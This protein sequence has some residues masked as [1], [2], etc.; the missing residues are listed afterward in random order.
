MAEGATII[1]RLALAAV[2]QALPEQSALTDALKA[3]QKGLM[4]TVVAGVLI[5]A[6]LLLGVFG[7]YLLLRS[8][9]VSLITSIVLIGAVLF[10]LSAI[11]VLIAERYLSKAGE[12]KEKIDPGDAVEQI[13]EPIEQI[14]SAF[15]NGIFSSPVRREMDYAERYTKNSISNPSVTTG[16]VSDETPRSFEQQF[17]RGTGFEAACDNGHRPTAGN[18]RM[19]G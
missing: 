4:A 18:G 2:G 3:T 13:T 8:E 16:E 10:M 7:F 1:K 15:I 19:K 17:Y 12:V 6:F 5:A 9:G 11:T 14:V